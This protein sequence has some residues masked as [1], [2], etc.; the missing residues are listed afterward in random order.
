MKI[1]L[2]VPDGFQ[3]GKLIFVEALEEGGLSLTAQN[4]VLDTAPVE[5]E[6]NDIPIKAAIQ[7]RDII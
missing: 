7:K 4:V 2:E 3:F 5:L 6:G 1:T